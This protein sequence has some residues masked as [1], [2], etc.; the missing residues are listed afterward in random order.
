MAASIASTAATETSATKRSLAPGVFS[1]VPTFFAADEELDLSTLQKHIVRLA[2]AGVG[3]VVAGSNGEA[4][5]LTVG[6][7]GRI[8]R[9]AREALDTAGYASLPLIAGTGAASTYETIRHCK[10]A[11][12]AG[13]D[14]VLV[15]TNS[16]YAASLARSDTAIKQF[17]IEVATASPVPILIYNYPQVS[18]IDLSS[19]T[20]LALAQHPRIQGCKLTCANVR[21][22]IQPPTCAANSEHRSESCKGSRLSRRTLPLR[23]T[24]ETAS[25]ASEDT[26]TSSWCAFDFVISMS[27]GSDAVTQPGLLA[28]SSGAITG[29]ANVAPRTVKRCF[30]LGVRAITTCSAEDLRA[31]QAIQDVVA[32]ADASLALTGIS[33]T[34]YVL[35][36]HWGYGGAPRRPLEPFPKDAVDKLEEALKEIIQMVRSSLWL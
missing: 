21:L 17:Y 13:A 7:R 24:V 32:R 8:V 19:D 33:G 31:A 20:I 26:P 35:Q 9:A 18:G 28:R 6:E 29:L 10:E 23:K 16:F 34:K 4:V 5:H 36:Q 3:S 27:A 12:E 15:L 11:A 2:A 25:T 14:Y 1:P 22:F 30:D